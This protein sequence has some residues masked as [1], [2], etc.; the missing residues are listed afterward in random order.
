MAAASARAF[1]GGRNGLLRRHFS[2]PHIAPG[3][4][5]AFAEWS[6]AST[7][8]DAKLRAYFS[9][10]IVADWQ[11]YSGLVWDTLNIIFERAEGP[12]LDIPR[13]PHIAA[14][15]AYK[16][17]HQMVY[18]TFQ[19]ALVHFQQSHGANRRGLAISLPS[20]YADLEL[21]LLKLERTLDSEVLA[22]HP[23]GYSTSARDL[24]RDLV[25]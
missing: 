3:L 23:S 10:R 22:A 4:P 9:A 20:H 17:A 7:Q 12:A 8:I 5:T 24:L 14:L 2:D 6:A 25:P 19:P 16:D 18:S 21:K 11:A 13:A 1:T 15:P